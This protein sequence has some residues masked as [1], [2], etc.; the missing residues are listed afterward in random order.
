MTDKVCERFDK[1]LS[2]KGEGI[3]YF[4]GNLF[5][6]Y[7]KN[8]VNTNGR[9]EVEEVSCNWGKGILNKVHIS[10][11]GGSGKFYLDM[12]CF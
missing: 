1:F 6:C 2:E 9:K 8:G 3:H 5:G 4:R 11:N 12:R 10:E 7:T